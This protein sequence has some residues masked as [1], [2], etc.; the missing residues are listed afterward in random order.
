MLL[1]WA[2]RPSL[3]PSGAELHHWERKKN[4]IHSLTTMLSLSLS[5]SQC[6]SHFFVLTAFTRLRLTVAELHNR[7]RCH[8]A[9]WE[10]SLRLGLDHLPVTYHWNLLSLLLEFT[11]IVCWVERHTATDVQSWVPAAAAAVV[12][13]MFM[14][15][16]S[17]TSFMS[18]FMSSSEASVSAAVCCSNVIR[19]KLGRVSCWCCCWWCC[20]KMVVVV[21]YYYW[22]L[23]NLCHAS[24]SHIVP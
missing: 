16:K 14:C 7:R 19:P 12:T 1:E 6:F 2:I 5:L 17:R 18:R 13:Q 21:G 22:E 24:K 10:K 23:V 3:L 4:L 11:A 20:R 15:V 8:A 9:W